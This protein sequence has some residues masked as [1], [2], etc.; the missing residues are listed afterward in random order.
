MACDVCIRTTLR[1]AEGYR[2]ETK[3]S[4]GMCAFPVMCAR[5]ALPLSRYVIL[6]K[7]LNLLEL[8]IFPIAIT[9]YPTKATYGK[10]VSF[11]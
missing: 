4:M 10:K 9:N 5:P 1:I 2:V 8:V 11:S 6:D 3:A 7:L